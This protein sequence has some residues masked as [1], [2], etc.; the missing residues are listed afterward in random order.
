MILGF[1]ILL[2]TIAGIIC[3]HTLAVPNRK[4]LTEEER[5]ICQKIVKERKAYP[6]VCR[7]AVKTGQCP[8]LPCDKLNQVKREG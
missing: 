5:K 7:Q 2:C 4:P 6:F 8:C 1:F 3:Y